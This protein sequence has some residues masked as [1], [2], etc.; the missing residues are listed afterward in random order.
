MYCTAPR[1]TQT[2]ARA[3]A[4]MQCVCVRAHRLQTNHLRSNSTEGAC[5]LL[6]FH[7]KSRCTVEYPRA[8]LY[9]TYAH[10]LISTCAHVSIL[11]HA[12]CVDICRMCWHMLHVLQ[13]FRLPY[14]ACVDMFLY[15]AQVLRCV[16][17]TNISLH[18]DCIST[19]TSVQSERH[20]LVSRTV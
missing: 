19:F 9:K 8:F 2:N 1:D 16:R 14:A 20:E 6:S 5:P 7:Q 15:T 18:R 3:R 13:V 17:T 10:V 4:H 11:A 12:A